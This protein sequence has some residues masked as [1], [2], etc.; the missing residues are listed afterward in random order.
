VSEA[1]SVSHRLS[2]PRQQGYGDASTEGL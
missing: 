2:S 1:T